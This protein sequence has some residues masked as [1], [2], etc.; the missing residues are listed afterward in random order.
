MPILNLAQK[1]PELTCDTFHTIFLRDVLNR[2]GFALRQA[3]QNDVTEA[4]EVTEVKLW[5]R[6][7]NCRGI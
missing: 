2:S 1:Y 4:A 5:N 6:Y 3:N 7:M